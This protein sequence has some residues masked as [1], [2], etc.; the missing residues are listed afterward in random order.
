MLWTFTTFENFISNIEMYGKLVAYQSRS[1]Q[2]LYSY[3]KNQAQRGLGLRTQNFRPPS[4][5]PGRQGH[6]SCLCLPPAVTPRLLAGWHWPQNHVQKS[7]DTQWHESVSVSSSTNV[8]TS[9]RCRSR[10]VAGLPVQ[11][12]FCWSWTGFSCESWRIVTNFWTGYCSYCSLA[13]TETE[14]GFCCESWRTSSCSTQLCLFHMK[15]PN[16]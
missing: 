5:V 11:P 10:I 9:Q 6:K 2:G 12:R 15:Q 7:V 13:S 8:S 3:Q 16:S 14:Q 4:G 1:C